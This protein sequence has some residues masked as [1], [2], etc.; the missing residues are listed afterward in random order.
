MTVD[1]ILEHVRSLSVHPV[2]EGLPVQTVESRVGSLLVTSA[3]LQRWLG[4]SK[5][6]TLGAGSRAVF[7]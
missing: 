7:L 6:R 4:L 3:T 2:W 1:T 5:Q